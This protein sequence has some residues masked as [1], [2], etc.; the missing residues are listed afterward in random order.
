MSTLTLTDVHTGTSF[1]THVLSPPGPVRAAVV[2]S[3]GGGGS[4]LLYRALGAS[5]AQHGYLVGLPEHPGNHRGD[6]SLADSPENLQG[7]PRHVRLVLD[8]LGA[9][10]A[11]V[12]GHSMGAYTALAVAGG[13]PTDRAG[14]AVEVESDGRVQALVLLA[15]VVYWYVLP[16]SLARVTAP[17]LVYRGARDRLA[18]AWHTQLVQDEAASQVQCRVLEN[19]GHHSFLHPL[20]PSFPPEDF[21]HE[22]LQQGILEFLREHV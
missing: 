12:I 3:H 4:P 11:A 20:P 2:I 9:A 19:A 10:K 6:N 13:A 14:Q 8:A 17:I 16:G 18:P 15:P 21:D 22:A 7:R 5:L 1:P